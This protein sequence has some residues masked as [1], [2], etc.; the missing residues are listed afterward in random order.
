MSILNQTEHRPWPLPSGPWI[1]KQSWHELLFAHW[2][3]APSI[4]KSLIPGVLNLDTFEGQAWIGVVPFRMK[5]GLRF[6]EFS[7]LVCT[8]PE[9]NVRTYVVVQDKP[10]IYFFS[11]EASNW[12]A[13]QVARVWYK[14][15]YMKAKMAV[16]RDRN[17]IQYSSKR[18]EKNERPAEFLGN[19]HPTTEVFLSRPGS[20][21]HWL[22]ER[23][24]LYAVDRSNNIYRGEVH[25]L[26]WPLQIAEAE[27]VQNTVP[28]SHGMNLPDTKPLL[29][30]AHRLEVFTWP[31]KRLSRY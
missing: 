7:P 17:I 29:H 12:L 30:Y 22:T 23:Y 31:P 2:P 10:G 6:L 9:L 14:L 5:I 8:F 3:I 24:C 25:H 4:L 11:L 26:P 15:S 20:L 21:E 27:I 16:R 28:L 13:V 18:T 1:I 19:Y